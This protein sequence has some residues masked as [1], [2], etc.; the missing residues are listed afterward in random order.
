M[1][2]GPYEKNKGKYKRRFKSGI[3][4]AL[5]EAGEFDKK[6]ECIKQAREEADDQADDWVTN[7]PEG[8]AGYIR[9]S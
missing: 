6:K 8:M 7:A 5:V 9:G 3:C 4:E 1:A 2:E